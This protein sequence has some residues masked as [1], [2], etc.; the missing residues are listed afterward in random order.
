[1]YQNKVGAYSCENLIVNYFIDMADIA[2][3]RKTYTSQTEN[4]NWSYDNKNTF[5]EV[6]QEIKM[7]YIQIHILS[8]VRIPRLSG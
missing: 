3:L 2:F 6:I 4:E 5:A 1:M 8:I 7:L